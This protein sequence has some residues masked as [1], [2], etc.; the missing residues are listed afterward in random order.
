MGAERAGAYNLIGTVK[1]LPS[2]SYALFRMVGSERCL[3]VVEHDKEPPTDEDWLENYI[4]DMEAAL[5]GSFFPALTIVFTSG[6]LPTTTQRSALAKMR[7]RLVELGMDTQVG[8][9]T[10]NII[11][12]V[13]SFAIRQFG[14][15][16]LIACKDEQSVF[17]NLGLPDE[18]RRAVM[19]IRQSFH[20]PRIETNEAA[21]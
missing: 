2:M 15:P 19:T 7:D 9:I 21:V 4:A 10:P 20:R 13:A 6:G 12:R 18:E 14:T 11:T 17:N 1:D 16:S 8:V 5:K 3:S